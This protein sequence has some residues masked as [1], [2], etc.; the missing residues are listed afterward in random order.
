MMLRLSALV[1][2]LGQLARA[3]DQAAV[4]FGCTPADFGNGTCYSD[5]EGR[6]GSTLSAATADACCT[7]CK[8]H[9]GCLAW[10]WYGGTNCNLFSD[11]GQTTDGDKSCVSGMGSAMPPR[12]PGHHNKWPPVDPQPWTCAHPQPDG[13]CI[14]GQC[15]SWAPPPPK[16]PPCKDC[17]NIVF[18]LTE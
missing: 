18:S 9:A 10:T 17:P 14:H 4:D 15:K 5:A 11:V 12:K 3:H 2:A 8:E 13:S 7:R 6:I 16:G 1:A